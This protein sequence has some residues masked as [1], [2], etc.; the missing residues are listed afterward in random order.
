MTKEQ[1]IY[2]NEL[3]ALSDE[4]LRSKVNMKIWLSA[5]ANNNPRSA[6]HWQCDAAYDECE[7]RNRLDIYKE[8]H[9]RLVAEAGG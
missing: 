7:R 4:A 2:A 8:E 9:Q 5:Y 6:F 3:Q 1:A